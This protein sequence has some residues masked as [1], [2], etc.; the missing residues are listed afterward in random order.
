MK[1]FLFKRSILA[2]LGILF[3]ILYF[4]H[5]TRIFAHEQYVLTKQQLQ[6]GMADNSINVFSALNNS[7][8]FKISLF[9]GLGIFV[10]IIAY[11][12]FQ[13]SFLGKKLDKI[14]SSLDPIGHVF[15][16]VALGA[17]LIMSAYFHSFLGPE[18][19]VTV[20]P[21]TTVLVPIMYVIGTLLL[22]GVFT[23]I[24]ATVGL[25]I[26]IATTFIYG[27]Y[28]VTYLNYYGEYIALIVFGSYVLSIDNK[29][30][31][32]S[33][34]VKKYKDI[35]LLII[36]V[37]YGISVMYPAITIKLLHP[38]VI[39]E[40]VNEYHLNQI[41][42]LFPQDS[43]LISL[44]TG[45]AQ[46]LV[47]AFIIVGFETRLAS[48]VTFFLYF[49]SVIYF[50]E[51]VWPHYVLLALAIYLVLNNGG[52]HALDYFIGKRF[53]KDSVRKK[54]GGPIKDPLV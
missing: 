41:H 4:S 5:T 13:Y 2:F 12:C 54:I 9:V 8:N 14:L 18:I 45:L 22:F 28:I 39:V 21:L 31:G 26:L 20:L 50:K 15:L 30:F 24:V 34:L 7:E 44:G 47:G 17:S 19:P 16:R 46:I 40:I 33:S 36:R 32:A 52:R 3:S 38:K 42:W 51:A 49:L 23:R 11:F 48:L 1:H 35:E 25:L 53:N 29:I 10:T 27:E 43:V 6:I 37:T